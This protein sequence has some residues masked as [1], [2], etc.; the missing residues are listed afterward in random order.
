VCC[1]PPPARA[2]RHQRQ[3]ADRATSWLM[4]LASAGGPPT[5][6]PPRRAEGC[7]REWGPARRW[8]AAA[9]LAAQ[10]V[11][12]DRAEAERAFVLAEQLGSVDAAAAE[13]GT[14][15]PSM[16]KPSSAT[17]WACRRATLRR[18]ASG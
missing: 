3:L 15:W 16:R 17:R 18:C 11:L 4:R 13:L 9:G 10:P 14:T 1:A 8:S 6:R 12:S 5:R 7:L 2:Y